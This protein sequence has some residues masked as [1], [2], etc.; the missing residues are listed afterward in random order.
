MAEENNQLAVKV[1]FDCL[2]ADRQRSKTIGKS[3]RDFISKMEEIK[4]E[5][6]THYEGLKEDKA[7]CA[8]YHYQY[9]RYLSRKS[10]SQQQKKRLILRI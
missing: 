3:D 1:N 7:L 9:G 8:H 4:K 10:E 5:F 2:L 6:E